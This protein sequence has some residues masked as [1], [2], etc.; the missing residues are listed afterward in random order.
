MVNCNP[1]TV[2]TDYD[3]SDRLYFEPLVEEFVFNIIKKEKT[4]GNLVGVIAQ[5]GGQTPIRLAKFLHKNKFPILGTQFTSIDLAEDRDRFRSLLNKLNLKQAQSGIAKTYSQALKI[6]DKIGLPLMVRPSYVLGG[7]AMEIVYKR[8]QLKEFILEAFKVSDKNPILIDKFID[9]AMEVDVDALS[10]GE[11][12]FVAGIMQHI[13]EAGIHSGDS[14]CSLPPVSIKSSLIKKIELQTKK[15]ALALKVKGF[16]NVQFAIKNDEIFVIEVNPRASRTVPFVSKAKNLPLAQIASRVMAGDKLSKFNLRIK[17][18][19]MFAVKE[20]VFPFNKFPK[21]DLLLGPEMKSTG[22]VMGFDENFGMAFAKSQIAA[23]NSLPTKG[24]AF[25]SLKNS[26]K[27]EGVDL[28]RQ[29]SKLNFKL[30]G[31][32]ELQIILIN[33]ELSAKK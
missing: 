26:H 1:E 9:N 3:T 5:F 18:K 33:M 19:K 8:K 32:V 27:A 22:E 14:A 15:L 28:A 6:A 10:D 30:C 21:S 29:L 24:L 25:I 20:A 11:Q 31:L 17:T 7:R 12:V 16:M 13:E 4:K 23:S 2:S